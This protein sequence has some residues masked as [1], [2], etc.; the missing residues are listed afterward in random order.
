MATSYIF[1]DES[2]T[3][4]FGSNLAG[5]LMNG[6]IVALYGPLG[7]GKT[8]VVRGIA[9]ALGIEEPVT[10]PSYTIV[11]EYE[12]AVPLIHIDLYRTSS[13]EEL[14]L[15]G[16]EEI[17]SKSGIVA[18]EWAERADRFLPADSIRVYIS[19]R[20]DGRE[21]TIEGS[22]VEGLVD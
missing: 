11:S 14:E 9:R 12:A 15:L 6:S 1:A 20:E 13:D 10:S 19:V 7:A 17:I 16:F 21:I 2:D 4:R 22:N 18:I 3:E 5:R 8:V